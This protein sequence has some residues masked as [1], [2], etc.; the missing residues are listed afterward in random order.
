MNRVYNLHNNFTNRN[1][2]NRKKSNDLIDKVFKLPIL[3]RPKNKQFQIN[4]E[5]NDFVFKYVENKKKIKINY[6]QKSIS[7]FQSPKSE[8]SAGQDIK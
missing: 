4:L 8:N 3:F 5:T 2:P 7:S 6:S 1:S